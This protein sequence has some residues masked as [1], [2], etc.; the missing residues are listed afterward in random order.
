MIC[1]STV[2]GSRIVGREQLVVGVLEAFARIGPRH[3]VAIRVARLDLIGRD[4]VAILVRVRLVAGK[5]IEIMPERRAIAAIRIEKSQHVVER[6]VLEHE[7]DDMVDLLQLIGHDTLPM[8]SRDRA[9]L[10]AF[11]DTE[12]TAIRSR[13]S[14]ARSRAFRQ[15]FPVASLAPSRQLLTRLTHSET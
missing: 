5:A 8:Q 2:P 7:I 4:A 1:V 3:Q 14:R 10:R 9:I 12:A 11:C 15:Y 13:L 6:P